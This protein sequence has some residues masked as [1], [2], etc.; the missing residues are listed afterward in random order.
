MSN[1]ATLA[2]ALDNKYLSRAYH[3]FI[4]Y[5]NTSDKFLTEDDPRSPLTLRQYLVSKSSFGKSPFVLQFNI[6]RGLKLHDHD[7]ESLFLDVVMALLEIPDNQKKEFTAAFRDGKKNPEFFFSLLFEILRFSPVNLQKLNLNLY[8]RVYPGVEPEPNSGLFSIYINY[9]HNLMPSGSATSN[10]SP[11]DRRSLESILELA[12]SMK[13]RKSGNMIVLAGESLASIASQLSSETNSIACF[14]IEFPDYNERRRVYEHTRK[15]FDKNPEDVSSSEFS[16]LSSGTSTNVIVSFISELAY[17]KKPILEKD[18]FEKKKKFIDE[19]SGGLMEVMRPLWG[20]EAIG[21]LKDHKAYTLEVIGNM[22]AGKVLAVPMGILL[23]GPP[24]TG[25]TVLAEALAH[26]ADI[27]LV[28]FKNLRTMW[29]GESERNQEFVRELTVAQ[30]PVV[31]FMDEFDQQFL[32]RGTVFHGD[33]GVNARMQGRFLEFMSDTSMRGKI[34]WIAATNMPG[35]LDMA[36]REGRFDDWI[37]FLPPEAEERISIFKALITKNRIAAEAMGIEFNVSKM[38]EDDIRLF[39]KMCFC[40]LRDGRLVK[41][42]EDDIEMLKKSDREFDDAIYF[43]GG[44]MEN[45]IRLGYAIA[46]SSD[47]PLAFKHLKSAYDEYNPPINMLKYN[48]AIKDAILHTNR[49]R[50]LPKSGRWKKFAE[51]ILGLGQDGGGF[52]SF[53]F[54][55]DDKK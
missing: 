23:M 9:L 52:G 46:L 47:E 50:F 39:A 44:Q 28:K 54:T 24:G 14:K 25:K 40:K 35:S 34:L 43:T 37:P 1:L 16:R 22:K 12:Q 17:S 49:L 27:P 20:L 48:D 18:I 10:Y 30:A 32:S 55:K 41:C 15:Q 33:S 2:K 5:L 7:K 38:S 4:F 29:H 45:L 19:K 51:Q 3:T 26:E 11:N 42:S 13:I 21:G 36:I 31:V 53:D 6:S 8:D